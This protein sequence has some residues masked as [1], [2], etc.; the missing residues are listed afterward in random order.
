MILQSTKYFDCGPFE[1]L[2]LNGGVTKTFAC[3]GAPASSSTSLSVGGLS[4]GA[5]GGIITA[6][7]VAGLAVIGVV[8]VIGRK[9]HQRAKRETAGATGVVV[10]NEPNPVESGELPQD[11]NYGR[12]ELDGSPNQVAELDGDRAPLPNRGRR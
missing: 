5:K 12:L 6:A 9:R 8:L 1:Q 2:N 4:A 7:I 10:T 11:E 3:L